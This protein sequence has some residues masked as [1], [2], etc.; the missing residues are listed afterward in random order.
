M[1]KLMKLTKSHENSAVYVNPDRIV[2]MY[3]EGRFTNVIMTGDNLIAVTE[4]PEE[5]SGMFFRNS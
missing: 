5:I 1:P 3:K 4:T 2:Y